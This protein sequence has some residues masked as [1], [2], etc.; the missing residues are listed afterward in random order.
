MLV[1]LVRLSPAFRGSYSDRHRATTGHAHLHTGLNEEMSTRSAGSPPWTKMLLGCGIGCGLLFVV[2]VTLSV[3]GFLWVS[4]PGV[5]VETASIL[6]PRTVAAFRLD[7]SGDVGR[8]STLL[9]ALIVELQRVESA[10]QRELLPESLQWLSDLRAAR[11]EESVE[12]LDDYIPSEVTVTIETSSLQSGFFPVVAVNLPQFPRLFRLILSWT[13]EGLVRHGEDD[14][15]IF[16]DGAAIAFSGGTIL[17]MREGEAVTDVLD[18]IAGRGIADSPSRLRAD[19]RQLQEDWQIS[20]VVDNRQGVVDRFF[21]STTLGRRL[22]G[23][24]PASGSV[25][26]LRLGFN[27]VS[28]DAVQ[29]RVWLN[30]RSEEEAREWERRLERELQEFSR[31]LREGMEAHWSL[32]VEGPRVELELMLSGIQLALIKEVEDRSGR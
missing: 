19:Y 17:W 21:D 10:R 22:G 30:C 14:Y 28:G 31:D 23:D 24:L 6:G 3:G 2:F 4:A 27:V 16:P 18:R 20:G 25:L 13:D 15:R 26:H 1:A 29:G 9:K 11:A 7:N 12:D 32:S 5:Q 8:V